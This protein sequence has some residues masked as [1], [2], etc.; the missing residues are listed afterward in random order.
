MTDLATALRLRQDAV[1]KQA[2]QISEFTTVR[3]TP[4]RD[5]NNAAADGQFVMLNCAS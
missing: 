5:E 1:A 2:Q 4:T 3:P